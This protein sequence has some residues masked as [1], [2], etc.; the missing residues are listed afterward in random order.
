MNGILI[1]ICLLMFTVRSEY[2]Y[3]NEP[4]HGFSDS[5][6]EFKPLASNTT[7]LTTSSQLPLQIFLRKDKL[8]SS[9][10]Y[11]MSSTNYLILELL[12]PN[13]TYFIKINCKS[14]F[15]LL[16]ENSIRQNLSDS[17]PLTRYIGEASHHLYSF[18]FDPARLHTICG[19]YQRKSY[20]F[21]Y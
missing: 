20:H 12:D 8:P 3:Y 21:K 16:L 6:F 10:E 11:D 18:S 9:S 14:S 2:L 13:S 1:S 15:S 7:T 5:V 19:R 17:L 4:V